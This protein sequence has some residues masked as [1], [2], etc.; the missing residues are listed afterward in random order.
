MT[1]QH[2]R[3]PKVK[4]VSLVAG[5]IC[6]DSRRGAARVVK[7]KSGVRIAEAGSRSTSSVHYTSQDEPHAPHMVP[8]HRGH[9][10]SE[11]PGTGPLVME[12]LTFLF[13]S[14]WQQALGLGNNGPQPYILPTPSS[15]TRLATLHS[16]ACSRHDF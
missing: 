4:Y 15:N 12:L 11:F 3:R 13:A 1:P 5:I 16:T 9:T 6:R 2:G 8:P 14:P 10:L 7:T